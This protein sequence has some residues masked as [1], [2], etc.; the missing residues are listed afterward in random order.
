G[1]MAAGVVAVAS[2]GGQTNP[3]SSPAVTGLATA[4]VVR[5]TLSTSVQVGGSIG[6]AGTYTISAPSGSSAQEVM[7]AQQ[8]VTQDQQ[9]LAADQRTESDAS[10]AD[11][12]TISSDQ[13]GVAT[14]SSTLESDMTAK[15]HD[16]AKKR[17]ATA[18]CTQ[19]VQKLSQDRAALVQAQQQL[20]GARAMGAVDHDQNAG[21]VS[22]DQTK[23]AGDRATLASLQAAAVNTG[24]TVT[25]LPSTGAIIRQDR[26][27]YFV[28]NE[29]V[30]LLYG[31]FP[32]YRAFYVGMSDGADV[33]QLTQDLIVLGDGAGLRPSEHYSTATAT[34]VE[35]WQRTLG[36]PATGQILLGQV[37]FEPGPIRVTSVTA[38]VGTSIGGG[39]ATSG[40][41]AGGGGGGGGATVLTATSATPV[42]S[43]QLEVTDE[44]LVKPGDTV[45]VVLPNGTSSVPGRIQ[46]VGNVAT[47]PGGGG[48]GLGNATA[49]QSPCASSGSGTS[50]T[51][52]VTVTI[53]LKRTPPEAK[54]DQAPVNVNI[55]SQTAKNVLAV[56]VNALLALQGG[57]YGVD[58]VTARGS[59]LVGVTTGL[60]SSALVQVSGTGIAPGMRVQ[61]PAS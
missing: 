36:L 26:P 23:L 56:P 4:A 33:A 53:R 44:Y 3:A 5:T 55:T 11:N 16:C 10:T 52:T 39:G 48:T 28:S 9:A 15:T 14:A 19:D 8:T 49:D 61:V 38:S 58:V 6:Y 37:V 54:L 57:G 47:C 41:G 30:P 13:T 12:R 27:V 43:V 35:R 24:T 32:A 46:T 7:Q 34:A 31:S 42:V 21:K 59:H 40:G 2:A 18:A 50:S 22:A 20:A 17:P 29:P 60:Y 25:W 45:S 51:P 1:A